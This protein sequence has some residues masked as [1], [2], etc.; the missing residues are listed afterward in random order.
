MH[1]FSDRPRRLKDILKYDSAPVIPNMCSTNWYILTIQISHSDNA[2]WYFQITHILTSS[3]KLICL[4]K[5]NNTH[6]HT[7]YYVGSEYA[8][9][10][11]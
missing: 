11:S 5:T 6:S 7:L 1:N 10:R 8:C 2:T 4:A 9:I 3:F